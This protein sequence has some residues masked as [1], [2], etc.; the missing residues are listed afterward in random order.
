MIDDERPEALWL[1]LRM[2]QAVLRESPSALACS[3]SV[4]NPADLTA[5]A[6]SLILE[7]CRAF[8]LAVSGSGRSVR[9][10]TRAAEDGR[11][12]SDGCDSVHRFPLVAIYRSMY[13]L[14]DASGATAMTRIICWVGARAKRLR[15][16]NKA[17]PKATSVI[18]SLRSPNRLW[19]TRRKSALFP[20]CC[21]IATFFVSSLDAALPLPSCNMRARRFLFPTIP[22]RR[23]L[24][25][26]IVT[27]L[28]F[29][30]FM[31]DIPLILF[32]P[33]PELASRR[34]GDTLSL[35]ATQILQRLDPRS[36][37]H[38]ALKCSDIIEH[39]RLRTLLDDPALLQIAQDATD[40]LAR[41]PGHSSQ[42][43]PADPLVEQ[44]APAT[45]VLA[46][47]VRE[48]EQRAGNTAPHRQE[49][50]S[51]QGLVGLTQARCQDG[52]EM[53]V[54]L[55]IV[56]GAVLKRLPG[57]VSECRIAQ[58]DG[59]C[60][61]RLVIDERELADDLARSHQRDD[62]FFAPIRRHRDFDQALLD[63]IAAI[64]AV[65]GHKERLPCLGGVLGRAGKQLPRHLRRQA[66]KNQARPL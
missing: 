34:N 12:T 32:L 37:V 10:C 31:S 27:S 29:I 53:L 65:A 20:H 2:V 40:V 28:D 57:D 1:A 9:A 18:L 3:S 44:N 41:H 58:S 51:G 50:R 64:A 45:R 26:T 60:R 5:S 16:A 7:D 39:V 4:R 56:F 61:P 66:G 38:L 63:A 43:L 46:D 49:A 24:S 48:F 54:D 25:V 59:R 47:I 8:V 11:N 21:R 62:A 14:G 42:V 13:A 36:V 35:L 55:R 19:R 6:S 23:T 17:P 33:A 52:R 30:F 22:T 15:A